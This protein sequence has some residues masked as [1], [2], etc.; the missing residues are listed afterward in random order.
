MGVGCEGFLKVWLVGY[1]RRN[2]RKHVPKSEFFYQKV[3]VE[4]KIRDPLW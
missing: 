4:K 1:M 2:A 3:G